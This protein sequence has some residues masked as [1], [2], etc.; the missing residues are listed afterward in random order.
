[1]IK[2]KFLKT[3]KDKLARIK[4]LPIYVKETAEKIALKNALGIVISYQD[5][6][7]LDMLRLKKLHKF[8]VSQKIKAGYSQPDTP[9]YGAGDGMAETLYNLLEIHKPGEAYEIKFSNETHHNSRL[10][11]AQIHYIHENGAIIKVTAKMRAF[12][13]FAGLHLKPTTNII[14]IPPR[15]AYRKAVKRAEKVRR[16]KRYQAKTRAAIFQLITT[17]KDAKF[18]ALQKLTSREKKAMSAVVT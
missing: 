13:H 4:R 10:S 16:K 17:G 3:F 12:L 9:L 14:R 6:I 11:I 18:K 1:M 5:G 15:P 7:R 8:S 2:P